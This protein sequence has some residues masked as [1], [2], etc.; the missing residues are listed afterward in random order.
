MKNKGNN[1][2]GFKILSW[3]LIVGLIT[4][5][6][7]GIITRLPGSFISGLLNFAVC[8]LV[9]AP[10]GYGLLW[11]YMTVTYG[12]EPEVAAI[13]EPFKTSY[14]KVVL[15]NFMIAIFTMLWTCLLIIPGI[16]MGLAYSQAN[17]IMMEHPEMTPMECIKESKRIMDGR[18]MDLFVLYLSFI[19]WILLVGITFGIASIYVVPYMTLTLINFYH[20]I[21]NGADQAGDYSTA[22]AD[23]LT[24]TITD[25]SEKV[26]GAFSAAAEK[27]GDFINNNFNNKN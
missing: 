23:A 24:G 16:I 22:T 1:H 12:K 10:L 18:K 17:F 13:F 26:E 5:A 20:R 6:V 7:E 21:K 4:G 8:L 25:A 14:G 27:A 3:A 11:V 19:P 2:L 15:L 9:S